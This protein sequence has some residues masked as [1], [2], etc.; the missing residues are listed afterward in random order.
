[1]SRPDPLQVPVPLEAQACRGVAGACDEEHFT[2]SPPTLLQEG[3][4]A[5]APD[6]RHGEYIVVDVG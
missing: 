5:S 3:A 4:A 2:S 6:A 1:M